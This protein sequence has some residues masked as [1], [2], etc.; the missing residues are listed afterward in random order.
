MKHYLEVVLYFK[1]GDC[2]YR[3]DGSKCFAIRDRIEL[4]DEEAKDYP[5]D[6]QKVFEYPK[7]PTTKRPHIL[8]FK[9]T[10]NEK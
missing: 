2:V 4:S 7:Q 6:L 1:E 3:E 9:V 8:I 10:K 5:K